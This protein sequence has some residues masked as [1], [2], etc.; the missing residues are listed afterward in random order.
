MK[1][2]IITGSTGMIALALIRYFLKNE[3]DTEI[4]CVTHSG[5]KKIIFIPRSSHVHLIECDLDH[6]NRL[7][8]LI[9]S[10]CDVFFHFAWAGTFGD[11]RNNVFLQE[12]NVQFTLNAVSAAKSLGCNC[13]IGAGSQAEYGCASEDLRP[14]THANPDT[15]YG[16]AKY[17]AGKLSRTLCQNLGIRH[18]WTRILS[19]YGPYDGENTMITSC[20]R[21]F[22]KNETQSFTKGEQ[23]WDY[24]YCDDAARAIYLMA[25]KGNDGAVYPL[26]S[27]EGKLLSD[28]IWIIRDIVA[29]SLSPAFG[30]IPYAKNQVMHLCADISTLTKDTG[31]MPEV[32]FEDGIR[33]TKLWLESM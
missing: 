33:A 3:P 16:I 22:L 5:S 20:I 4:F 15:S 9:P 10:K 1:K 27:G 19:I 26:G 30:D 8:Q 18:V 13:F 24:L 17:A 28:Y 21:S 6:Y 32:S 23:V 2:V 14:D 7:S 29:P 31:F 25:E 12:K 11:N